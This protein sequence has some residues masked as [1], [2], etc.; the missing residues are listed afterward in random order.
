MDLPLTLLNL[1]GA[2]R[3]CCGAC[4][5]SHTGVQRAFGADLR[6]FLGA[7]LRQPL[8]RLR[9]RPRRHRGAAEQHRDRPDG[10]GLRRRRLAS[11]WRRAGRDARRQC[12]HDADRAGVVFRRRRDRAGADP[13]RR[14]RCSAARQPRTRDL[15]RVRDRPRPDADGACTSFSA[16][17]TPTKTCRACALLLGAVDDRTGA[18]RHSRRR[19]DLG[20]AFE[21]RGR[22]GGH[23]AR[24]QG[25]RAAARRAGD[26]ARRQ[27]RQRRINPVLEG[28][29]GA[30]PAARRVPLG[31]LAQSRSSA[32]RVALALLPPIAPL[33]VTVE[34][35]NAAPGRRF[36][37]RVQSRAG[38]DLPAVADAVRGAA[39]AAAAAA[40]RPGRP[41]AAA[42][43]RSRRAATPAIALGGA[44]REAL[45]LADALESDARRHCATR[46]P[47][48]IAARSSRRS[49]STTC[50]TS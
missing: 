34:P 24:G 23:V 48:P 3:C 40:R 39:R 14:D 49:G 7:A 28:A 18:R 44:A 2:W 25:N 22:A 9:R 26:G 20:G 31:N 33:L 36:P 41:V 16:L 19:A 29:S 12:R 10:H 38:A 8:Q 43:S 1:A 6:S 46:S 30:D 27:S 47:I 32:S 50:S 35:D 4:I 37:H 45:R 5:W 13:D 15:G 11:I 21:R 17:L 42:L